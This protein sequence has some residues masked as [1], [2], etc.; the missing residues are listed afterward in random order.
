MKTRGLSLSLL[1]FS[2][3]LVSCWAF[4][5]TSLAE[6]QRTYLGWNY[7]SHILM[8][9]IGI[10][11]IVAH[12]TDFHSY[13]FTLNRWRFD[14][15]IGVTCLI[16]FLGFMPSFILP[17]IAGNQPVNS[18]FEVA[19]II[20]AIGLVANKLDKSSVVK[21]VASIPTYF[22]AAPFLTP[23]FHTLNSQALSGW[24]LI[25]STAIFQFFF[26][27]FGEEI[28]FRGYMQTRLNEDFGKPWCFKGVSFG[29]GL[30]ISSILFGVLHLLNPFNPLASSYELA[31]WS[32]ITSSFA[33]LLFGVVRE[34]TGTVLSASLAHG[35][36]DLGQV[37]PLFFS[38]LNT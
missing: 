7:F 9:V 10:G 2:L 32:A 29:P 11:M 31:V 28:L 5:T 3:F 19:A 12:G 20:L 38:V 21:P 18:F 17:S 8:I 35:L 22:L 15:R 14:L 1:I 16:M 24:G 37:I 36:V 27:G 6:A 25:A 33:G 23:S 34:K 4:N 13:G 30:L 26:A